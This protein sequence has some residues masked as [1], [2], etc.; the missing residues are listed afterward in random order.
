[1]E[2]R[3][4][5]PLCGDF[6]NRTKSGKLCGGLA[7]AGTRHCRM[8]SGKTLAKARAE[9]N[10]VVELRRWGLNPGENTLA[11]P[12]EVLL[13][14]VTQSAAR[15]ELY[16]GVLQ[17]AYEA[18]EQLRAAGTT[19][20]RSDL[21]AEETAR[22]TL[23][24]VFNTGGVGALIGHTYAGTQSSGVI[25]TGEKI[26]GLAELEA[27]ER[28][29]CANFA[30]KAIAAG[31]AERQVRFAERQGQLLAA[32]ITTLTEHP[33]LGLTPQQQSLVPQLLPAV[34][35]QVTGQNLN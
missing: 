16:A 35:A 1:M 15:C 25:A 34:V 5:G 8:H 10:V 22:L 13:R 27:Q 28:D 7:I 29:R 12:G 33:S 4:R 2:K 24:R 18:A 31:L 21:L 9:G 6:G 20:V 17:Q 14:L 19:D 11:D 23:E 32:I 30:T 3:D 26:R